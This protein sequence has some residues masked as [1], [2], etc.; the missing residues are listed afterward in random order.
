MSIISPDERG[1]LSGEIAVGDLINLLTPN[2][3]TTTIPIRASI[4]N[5]MTG[6]ALGLDVS[7]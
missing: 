4:A 5:K 7:L 6:F 3:P 2:E 1:L